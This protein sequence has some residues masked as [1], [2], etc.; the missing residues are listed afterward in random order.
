MGGGNTGRW[1]EDVEMSPIGKEPEKGNCLDNSGMNVIS[2]VTGAIGSNTI[3]DSSNVGNAKNEFE[4]TPVGKP[5][6]HSTVTQ[7]NSTHPPSRLKVTSVVLFYIVTSIS[8]IMVNKTVLNHAGL[9]LF[10]LWGQLIVAVVLLHIASLVGLLTLPPLS[11][12]LLKSVTPLILINVVGLVLNT[13]CLQHIDAVMYQV[14][15]SL[16]LPMTVALGPIIARN[17]VSRR[18]LL[19]CVMISAGFLIGIFGER[20]LTVSTAGVIFGVASSF[21]TALHS[22]IIKSSFQNVKHNGAFDLVYYNNLFSALF[23]APILLFELPMLMSFGRA[24][25]VAAMRMFLFGTLVAGATGLLINL[26]GFLQ[27]KTTSPITHTVASAAR[28]V[29]QSMA[30]NIFLGEAIT[31]A[32]TIGITVTLFGSCAYSLVKTAEASAEYSKVESE[33]SRN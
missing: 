23:L 7:H 17:F 12:G 3:Q 15:R 9:P 30:A 19:C 25:G 13:L 16:I 2:A 33:G 18:V 28:G 27:I 22:Y 1:S 20:R 5:R 14:A 8:M 10:F 6:I 26:A 21:T 4:M 32:R 24:H 11:L 29:L 31:L